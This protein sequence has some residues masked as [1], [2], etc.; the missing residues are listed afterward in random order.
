MLTLQQGVLVLIPSIHLEQSGVKEAGEHM[1]PLLFIQKKKPNLWVPVPGFQVPDP[2]FRIFGCSPYKEVKPNDP[3]K[4]Q[5]L[6][7]LLRF[8]G[9]VP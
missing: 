1:F 7:T 9:N 4:Q 8:P 6:T 3:T 5:A 2:R